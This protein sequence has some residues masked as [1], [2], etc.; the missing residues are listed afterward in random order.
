M[1]PKKRVKNNREIGLTIAAPFVQNMLQ[2][3]QEAGLNIP[4]LLAKFRIPPQVLLNNNLRIPIESFS[5]LTG[6]IR[7]QLDDEALGLLLTPIKSGAFKL[8]SRACLTCNTI[9]ESLKLCCD[10]YN[11]LDLSI[12]F[13]LK[14][15][16]GHIY[17]SAIRKVDNAVINPY[18]LEIMLST[19][20]RL[21]CWLVGE[22]IPIQ[23]VDLDYSEPWYGSEYRFVFY[24]APVKFNQS[25]NCIIFD[26]RS[27]GLNVIR[28]ISDLKEFL[29]NVDEKLLAQTRRSSSVAFRLRRWME[30]SIREQ[31][32]TPT[33]EEA[34]SHIR[35]QPQT[36]RRHLKKEGTSYQRIKEDTRRDIAIHLLD[37]GQHNI[38][39]IAWL[40]GFS[41]A[42][43]FIRSFKSWLGVTPL[44]YKQSDAVDSTNT[45]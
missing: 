30:R 41:E 21:Q 12:Y 36:L 16:S 8:M 18:I 17:F 40:L 20:H 2:G 34:S 45:L 15:S 37:A 27:F 32:H 7:K 29:P 38:E 4:Q 1:Y 5:Q 11:L 43:T 19:I 10:F 26:R 3:G 33:M 44:T 35:L 22:F 23:S 39:Q 13:D 14:E 42:S 24:G 9:F 31:Q 28:V 25:Q 6:E